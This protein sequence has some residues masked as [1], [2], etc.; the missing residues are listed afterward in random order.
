MSK[1][2]EAHRFVDVSDY[3]RP[4]AVR[5]VDVILPTSLNSIH[6]TFGFLV[7]G[8]L[9]MI[10]LYEGHA[11][12]AALLLIVKNILDAADGELARARSEPRLTGRYLDSIFDFAINLGLFYTL[13]VI[14]DASLALFIISFICLEL[15]CSVFNFYYLIQRNLCNG[16]QTSNIDEFVTPVAYPYESQRVVNVLHKI[17]LILYGFQDK[18]VFWLD[19]QTQRVQALPRW[20]MTTV[21]FMGLGF[22]ILIIACLL[23][24]GR[25]E[26]IMP[27]FL[28]YMLLGL[29]II[30]IRKSLM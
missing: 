26:W 8:I 24:I 21:S 7:A 12:L 9:S 14:T 28:G 17:Y 2:P 3:G 19:G 23:L 4:I 18:I 25:I 27:F 6:V 15:Q 29:L 10:A 11:A 20:F 30:L 1:L 16:D 13:Y 22:Q 5:L